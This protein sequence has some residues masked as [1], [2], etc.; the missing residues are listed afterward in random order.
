MP[1]TTTGFHYIGKVKRVSQAGA[2]YRFASVEPLIESSPAGTEW[3]GSVRDAMSLFP[4]RGLIH[5]HD[6]PLRLKEGSLWQFAVDE[7]PEA[8]RADRPEQY[9]L[10]DPQE[11]YELLDLRG[12]SQESPLRSAITSDGIPLGTPPLVGRVLIW[13]AGDVCV[14][15]LAVKP[16]PAQPGLWTIDQGEAPNDATRVPAWLVPEED[17]QRVSLDGTRWFLAPRV[18]LHRSTGLQNWTPDT[19]V[20]RSILGRLRKMDR[21]LVQALGFTENLFRSYLEQIEVGRLGTVDAALERARADRLVCVRNAI[22]RDASFLS[23]AAE[24]LLSTEQIQAEVERRIQFSVEE[25]LQA[26][27]AEIDAAVVGKTEQLT[28]LNR[29]LCEKD[30]ERVQLESALRDQQRRLDERVASFEHAVQARLEE[31][32][33][34]PEEAFADA[35]VMR[36]ILAPVRRVTGSAPA[37]GLQ[38]PVV[39]DAE[40]AKYLQENAAVRGAL[41]AHAAACGLSIHSILSLHAA[42]LAGLAPVVV[43]S[44][45]Y[46]LVRAYASAI[47]GGRLHWVPTA[48][49]TMEPQDVLG[50]FDPARAR[51]MPSPSGLLDVARESAESGRLHIVVFDGFNRGP[52]EGYLSPILQAARARRLGDTVRTIPLASPALLEEG[53]PYRGL[54]RLAWPASLPIACLPSDGSLTLPVP[55]SAWRFMALIDADDRDRTPMPLAAADVNRRG[56]TEIAP[57]LWIDSLAAVGRVVTQDDGP[58]ETVAKAVALS[59][60]DALDALRMRE[61]LQA[62]TLP[63]PD[64]TSLAIAAILCARSQAGEKAIEQGTRAIGVDVPGWRTVVNEAQRLRD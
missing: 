50:R 31:I 7:H 49:S 34:A 16:S 22:Q 1:T 13:L 24:A 44:R 8:E 52:V 5:W 12:W 35:A 28:K 11:A 36:A 64:A 23:E 29:E 17:I 42:F 41:A 54:A 51:I 63:D 45:G 3:R 56:C 40:P 47:A 21:E 4:R 61:V 27:R 32:A 9:Q 62:N 37:T 57:A 60:S 19:Q 10:A 38:R 18:G 48:S 15:P 46:D 30:A 55:P 33:R 53:D 59:A 6:A 43:G 20:A 58:T 39:S 2:L 26:R 25:A 14:G